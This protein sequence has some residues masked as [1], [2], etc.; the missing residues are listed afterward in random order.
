MIDKQEGGVL[1]SLST[2][3]R[4]AL[5]VWSVL[6][7]LTA[8]RLFV[9]I[10]NQTPLFFD[11]AYYYLWSQELEYGYHSK[12]PMIAWVI[13]LTTHWL[14]PSE[15]GIKFGS[16]ILYPAT[17]WVVFLVARRLFDSEIAMISAVTFA[18]IPV[19]AFNTLLITTDAVL[20]FFWG[21]ALLFFLRALSQDRVYDW[22]FAG[23]FCGCGLLSKYAMLMFPVS[24]FVYLYFSAVHHSQLRNPKLYFSLGI[25]FLVFTPNLAWNV[26]HG[27]ATFIHTASLSQFDRELFN[28]DK[29]GEFLTAQF[30]VFGPLFMGILCYLVFRLKRYAADDRYWFLFAFAL[31]FLACITVQSWLTRANMHWAAPVYFSSTILVSAFLMTVN[32]R[33][34]LVLGISVNLLLASAF[35]H[36]HDLFNALN[37]ELNRKNDPYKKILGW[38]EMVAEVQPVVDESKGFLVMGDHRRELSYL[39][40]YLQ[41]LLNIDKVAVWNPQG[42]VRSQFDMRADLAGYPSA[43]VI[44]VTDDEFPVEY[45]SAFERVEYVRKIHIPIYKGVERSYHVYRLYQFKGYPPQDL[46]Q[47]FH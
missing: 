5:I 35:Y 25:A 15:L 26:D 45:H 24:I 33:A 14:G 38:R 13:H 22:F 31:P 39:M 47:D 40:Y 42:Q 12:P 6:L 32:W 29:M 16:L 11:E 23:L 8:Y 21:L 46:A 17:A 9:M 44:Y 3:S 30:L 41:P 18:T 19:V 10:I 27:F 37:L 7:L 28:L 1:Q 2:E 34:V 4:N 36:Y 43:N 20:F